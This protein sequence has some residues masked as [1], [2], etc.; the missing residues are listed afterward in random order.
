MLMR[1]LNYFVFVCKGEND[2]P[3]QF[4]ESHKIKKIETMEYLVLIWHLYKILNAGD[5]FM[6][7]I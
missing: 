6:A 5:H 4:S 1:H 7:Y 3:D 2:Y